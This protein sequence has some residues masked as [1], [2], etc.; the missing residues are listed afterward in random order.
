MRMHPAYEQPI[1]K[2]QL[3]LASCGSQEVGLSSRIRH[4]G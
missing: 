2:A 1:D 3:R 4:V